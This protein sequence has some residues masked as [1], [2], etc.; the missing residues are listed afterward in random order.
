MINELDRRLFLTTLTGLAGA[1]SLGATQAAQPAAPAAGPLDISWFDA[2]SRSS[3][4][5]RSTC[6]WT[7]RCASR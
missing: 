3:I 1:A 4:S 2:F 7:R 6:R 5:D